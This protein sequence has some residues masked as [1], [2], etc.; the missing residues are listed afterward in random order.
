MKT[1]RWFS[2]KVQHSLRPTV[3]AM[4]HWVPVL[5]IMDFVKSAMDLKNSGL[6][7]MLEKLNLASFSFLQKKS[8]WTNLKRNFEKISEMFLS[9]TFPCEDLEK[10][11]ACKKQLLLPRVKLIDKTKVI[12]TK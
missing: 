3:G 10:T 12:I 2:Q 9:K 7:I 4:D 5:W 1:W 8:Q 11:P 6:D